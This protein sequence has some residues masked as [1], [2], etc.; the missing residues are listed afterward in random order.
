[1]TTATSEAVLAKAL[2]YI[3]AGRLTVVQADD[4]TGVLVASVA[5]DTGTWTVFRSHAGGRWHCD[6]PA[7]AR[8]GRTCAHQAA[9]ALVAG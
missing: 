5:G 7:G 9:V 6:C 1:M 4:T 3:A 8:F 2:G